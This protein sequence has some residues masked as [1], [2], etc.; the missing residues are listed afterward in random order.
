MAPKIITII[1]S[2][3]YDLVSVTPRVPLGGETLTGTSFHTGPGGKGANQAVATARLSRPNPYS[4][5]TSSTPPTTT[6]DTFSTQI[7]VRML[8]AVG[9]DE[10]GPKLVAGMKE[11]GIDTTGISLVKDKPTGVAVILVESST[12]ENRILLN[13]GANYTLAASSFLTPQSLGTPLPDLLVLQLEIPLETVL[14]ILKTA[15]EAGV[16]VLLNPAPAVELP[17]DVYA[18]ITHLILNETEA[19]ILTSREVSDVEKDDFDWGIVTDEFLAKG[20]KNVVVTLGSKGAYYAAA[21]AAGSAG[22]AG[23]VEAVKVAKVVDTTAAGDTFVGAY[24]VS[25]VEGTLGI[26][27]V[28]RWAC[29]ASA[30]TVQREG[31]QKSIPWLDEI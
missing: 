9:T 6:Q 24:A 11:D 22:V 3:N 12:G 13:P 28:V 5:S 14:Q 21:G 7:Q 27:D 2:L 30:R 16:H 17:A 19:A 1:G 23:S 10:F 26:G 15:R 4:S 8:G 20:V 18:G 25:V 31:A 29:R